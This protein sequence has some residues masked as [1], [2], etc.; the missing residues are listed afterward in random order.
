LTNT[1]TK[2]TTRSERLLVAAIVISMFLW[3]LSWPANKVLTGYLSP[4]N[5]VIIRYIFVVLTMFPLL[6][7]LKVPVTGNRKGIPPILI[8]G[9]L[10]ALYSYIFYLGLVHGM[11]GAGG[12]LVTTLNP[13]AAYSIGI[14]IR[15]R[16]PNRSE[17]TGLLIGLLAGFILLKVW[18][19][20][21]S[22]FESGNLFFL[23]ASFLWAV[24]SVFTSHA[25]KFGTSFAFS[26]WQYVVALIC[27]LPLLNI[28]EFISVFS[29]TDKIFWLNMFFSSVIVTSVATTIYF[30][31]TMKVGPERASSFIFLVPIAAETSAWIF[32]DEPV[33][34]HTI[35]GGLLGILAVYMINRSR[36]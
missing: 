7:I 35:I 18:Q 25:K 11:A 27:M 14:V 31:A 34:I 10:L 13:I 8:S 32:L 33:L 24:M 28:H 12:V 30:Y 4:V 5:F 19:N 15:R 1:D 2:Y 3:G 36:K 29:I 22:I 21:R 20:A 17:F 26:F 23:A 9:F 6:L 16:L